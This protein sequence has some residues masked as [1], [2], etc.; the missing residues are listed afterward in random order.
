MSGRLFGFKHK[1]KRI[2]LNMR[3]KL[4][5]RRITIRDVLLFAIILALVVVF[6]MY[7]GRAVGFCIRIFST[8]WSFTCNALGNVC[9]AFCGFSIDFADGKIILQKGYPLLWTLENRSAETDETSSFG[10]FLKK[11]LVFLADVDMSSPRDLLRSEIRYLSSLRDVPF[12]VARGYGRV[13]RARELEILD[14]E[15]PGI[16]VISS[17][18][19]QS[20]SDDSVR[21]SQVEPVEVDTTGR[22]RDTNTLPENFNASESRREW[23]PDVAAVGVYYTHTSESFKCMSGITHTQG[24]LG[25]IVLI[26]R[27]FIR[28]LEDVYGIKVACSERIHDYP[29]WSRAYTNAF[30]TATTLVK[31]NP[32][33][34]VLLDLHRDG[35]DSDVITS[36]EAKNIVTARINGVDVARILIVVTTDDFGLSHPNWRRNYDFAVRLNSKLE[37]MYPGL[38]RGIDLRKDA[39]FNQHVHERALLVE[40]GGYVSEKEELLRSIAMLADVIAMILKEY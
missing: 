35:F 20:D 1:L 32:S 11:A 8:G 30:S 4:G 33:L 31:G 18:T 36:K 2:F 23:F 5:Y 13:E 24:T 15:I 25:D 37:Q 27:E 21:T 10:D 28:R 14:T 7:G 16:P 12:T 39:R 3:Y 6:S 38:S 17:H 29:N 26:G 9:A 34:K 19:S 40:I 22:V